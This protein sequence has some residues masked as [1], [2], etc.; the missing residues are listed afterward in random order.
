MWFVGKRF[1]R[2]CN[3]FVLGTFSIAGNVEEGGFCDLQYILRRN[4]VAM[5]HRDPFTI[6]KSVLNSISVWCRTKL[7][8]IWR[9]L[10]MLI[11][12]REK[13]RHF[14]FIRTSTKEKRHFK[15]PIWSEAS[16][17][18]NSQNWNIISNLFW[19]TTDDLFRASRQHHARYDTTTGF[20]SIITS[21][22]V[23]YC[24][25]HHVNPKLGG[26][27]FSPRTNRHSS[28]QIYSSPLRT[29]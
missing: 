26:D 10:W 7:R 19:I 24:M 21:S 13:K 25:R 4:H 3:S 28:R 15:I 29:H 20:E 9:S 6:L 27:G 14:C 22:H 18:P 5:V 8:R 11:G 17:T 12:V 2:C 16:Q 1:G 23:R